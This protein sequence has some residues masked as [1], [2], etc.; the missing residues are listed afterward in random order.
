MG[1]AGV[2]RLRLY[3]K[4]QRSWVCVVVFR[5]D[6]KVRQKSWPVFSVILGTLRWRDCVIT[7]GTLGA[8]GE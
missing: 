3:C 7:K 4:L 6:P 5:I 8:K 1:I 2:K